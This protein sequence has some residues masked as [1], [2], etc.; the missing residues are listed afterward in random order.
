MCGIAGY[1]G[2]KKLPQVFIKN[3]L[4]KMSNRGPDNQN[5]FYYQND[6]GYNIYLLSSRLSIVNQDQNSNQPFRINEYVIVYNGEIYNFLDLR[7]KLIKK[8]I[9]VKTSSDTEVILHYFI[10]YGEKCLKYFEG[11]W[12]FVILNIKN[13]KIFS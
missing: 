3:T 13:N 1:I 12:S 10:L 2:R 7:K 9:K 8:G 6:N 5:F 11:M 4:R